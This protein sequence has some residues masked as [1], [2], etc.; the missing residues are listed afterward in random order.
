VA[1]DCLA[2]AATLGNTQKRRVARV[3]QQRR[4]TNMMHPTR[5]DFIALA[6]AS[7]LPYPA[8]AQ[9]APLIARAIPSSGERIPAVGLGTAISGFMRGSA[10]QN[11]AGQV[12]AALVESG[13]RLIDTASSY[14]DAESVIGDVMTA[15]N[16]RP[17]IFIATKLE[18]PDAD[19]L[20]RSL[21]RLRTDKLDLLQLHNVS[22]PNQ[23]M[24]KFKDWKAQGICRYTGITSTSHGDFA[25]VES[26][27]HR[28]RP[29]FVQI[30][31]SLDDRLA[32]SRVLPAAA[33]VKAGVLT[34][35]PFGHGRLFRSVRG[36]E[37]P[38]WAR[39]FAQSWAQFFLKYLLADERVTAVI[40][41][42]SDPAHMADNLGAL[43]GPLPD[44][45]TRRRMVEF[46][47]SL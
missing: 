34:A 35:L 22:D 36:T 42:T 28:E 9:Q 17:K 18:S 41:G 20:K 15:G 16:L 11:A 39:A 7:L 44:V 3:A 33:E 24:A 2:L 21:A 5:R 1:L 4:E 37:L 14:G 8:A 13:G 31:Y 45:A 26:V 10:A 23:A 25:A 6:A 27:L 30:D 43:R 29:D 47:Q 19:E 40:P 46:A 38:D 32:E 12:I